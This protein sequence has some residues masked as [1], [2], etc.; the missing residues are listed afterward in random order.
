M[1]RPKQ[2]MNRIGKQNILLIFCKQA[3]FYTMG[4]S[5]VIQPAYIHNIIDLLDTFFCTTFGKT[6]L[7]PNALAISFH[8]HYRDYAH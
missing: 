3:V 5:T 4:C 1:I 2:I 7:L 8:V 6:V